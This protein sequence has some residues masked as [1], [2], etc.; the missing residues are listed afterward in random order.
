MDEPQPINNTEVTRSLIEEERRIAHDN[1]KANLGIIQIQKILHYN[2]LIEKRGDRCS[3]KRT[4]P[5][6]RASLTERDIERNGTMTS[7]LSCT[8]PV[9]S[10][11]AVRIKPRG[12]DDDA[13]WLVTR[14]GRRRRKFSKR[15]K[16]VSEDVLKY[17]K[18]LK[19]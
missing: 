15:K 1:K 11:E 19:T 8:Q 14:S 16:L 7:T 4:E 17:E 3:T 10:I 18:S 6:A 5:T 2:L 9:I 12:G 13:T